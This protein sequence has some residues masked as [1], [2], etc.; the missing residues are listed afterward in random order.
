MHR[1][2]IIDFAVIIAYF[3][4]LVAIAAWFSR[5]QTTTERYFVG[6]RSVP[7]WAMG[8]SLMA[9]LISSITFVA[10]P[11]DAFESNW[12]GLVPGL[13]VPLV[14][15]LM[16]AVVIP[17][18]RQAVGMSAYEYFEKRFGYAARLY[19]SMS[20]L[21]MQLSKMAMV[22]YLLSLA[23]SSM[24]GWNIYVVLVSLEA[25][26]VLYVLIGGIEA[27]I[28]TSVLQGAV[29]T[30]G[31]AA[32]LAVL[33]FRPEGGPGAVLQDAWINDKFSLGGLGFDLTQPT[34]LVLALYGIAVYIQKYATDQAVVQRYLVAK[35]NGEALQG[36]L[37]GA[38]LCI[39]VWAMFLLIGSC[40]WSYYRLTGL[41]I[42]SGLR[43]DQVF[44]MFIVQQLPVGITGLV[45]AALIATAIDAD[46]NS[47][48][49]VVVEDYY[50]QFRPE[51]T[52]RERLAVGKAMVGVTGAITIAVA[53]VLAHSEGTALKLAFQIAS[54]VSGGV[55]GLFALAFL[56]ARATAG[57]A[58]VGIVASVLFTAWATLTS[59][60]QW[61]PPLMYRLD[62][63]L[64]G[65][66]AT[67]ILFAVGY[68][69][70]P[71]FGAAAD[72]TA[73][74]LPGWLRARRAETARTDAGPLTECL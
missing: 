67:L 62:P 8:I 55:T 47:I 9:T 48:S 50:R 35:S 1:L 59:K 63:L 10:Y 20:F 14:L 53:A 42:D 69:A 24:A 60:G 36:T 28:W 72:C 49:V 3:A 58:Y 34:F 46:L 22:L 26:T 39:P 71:L 7:W 38:L 61:S 21:L 70:S 57:G 25:V 45:L 12:S 66:F 18:Y 54:V 44:P 27:V 64:I 68:A 17:F 15:L 65:V 19:T 40:L 6:A 13:M 56:S 29:L 31:G 73:L 33:L 32:C 30:A 41:P 4:A 37:L 43:P 51:T 23:L 5:R 52:D 16:A 11:G 74:T 2:Q